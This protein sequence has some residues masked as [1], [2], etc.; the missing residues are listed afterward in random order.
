M[1]KTTGFMEYARLERPVISP[2]IRMNS[3]LEFHEKLSPRQRKEQGGRCMNCGVPFCQSEYG[4]PLHNLIP[5]WN[6]EI[7]AENM[8]HALS[9]LL[10]TNNFPEFTG[11]V[12]PALCENA[13]VC[14][15][16]GEPV[17]VRDNELSIIEYA[18]ASGLMDPK[19]PVFRSGKRVAVVGSGPAG[20]AVADQLNRRGHTVTVFERDDRPG[21]LLMYGIPNMKLDK[22]II[23]R[24]TKKMAA[25][26]IEFI[27]G[28]EIGREISAE[29][30]KEQYDAVIL[31]CGARNPRPLGMEYSEQSGVHFALDYLTDST[32]AFLNGGTCEISAAGRNVV[33]VGNGDT[34]T[35]CVATALRQGATSVTQLVRK[36]K[37]EN[38]ARVWPYRSAAEKVEYGQE[39][40]IARFGADP[41]LYK[42]TVQALITDQDGAL[43]A[44]RV[45]TGEQ[46]SELPAELL[47]LATGFA[48]AEAE[49]AEAFGLRLDERGRLG[50]EDYHTDDPM[51][52]VCGDMRI[53]ASL[54]VRAIAEGRSCARAVDAFL[55]GYTNL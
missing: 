55:E 20:L 53:G 8:P 50:G 16:N 2:D 45:K 42:T 28:K 5:E 4:C 51:V 48:G 33:I 13:C 6:D 30:L 32:K 40:A 23:L 43:R 49:T 24:R 12:C 17:T 47:L 25:E 19:P 27:C 1:S 44:V 46:E 22:E 9:R 38:A 41:R 29:Q 31:C 18:W 3:Y 7:F 34:A 39:E 35:D 54:V 15:M 26:G 10:K 21:G 37:P 52:F 14:G 36:A 11:R